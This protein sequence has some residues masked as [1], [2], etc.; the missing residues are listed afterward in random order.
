MSVGA[1]KNSRS[2]LQHGLEGKTD[3]G[4]GDREGEHQERN[5][6]LN[7]YWEA[8]GQEGGLKTGGDDW[9]RE[10]DRH[11]MPWFFTRVC[12]RYA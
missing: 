2:F 11:V 7:I 3:Q 9:R 8:R 1:A 12:R 6:R 10:A 5:G 4:D